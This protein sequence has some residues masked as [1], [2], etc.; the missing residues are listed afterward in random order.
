MAQSS[1]RDI[2]LIVFHNVMVFFDQRVTFYENN[3]KWAFLTDCSELEGATSLILRLIEVLGHILG[4]IVIVTIGLFFTAL[5][6]YSI[7]QF[8]F[9]QIVFLSICYIVSHSTACGGRTNGRPLFCP[10][11][12]AFHGWI[13]HNPAHS[14]WRGMGQGGGCFVPTVVICFHLLLIF[15]RCCRL[16]YPKQRTTFETEWHF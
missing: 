1:P 2:S 11:A 12:V 9:L 16:F 8:P 3:L 14:S 7:F 6:R 4:R 10:C 5:E 13:S 15:W